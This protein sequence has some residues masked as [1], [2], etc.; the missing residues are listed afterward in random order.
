VI[1]VW[2]R[3]ADLDSHVT[4]GELGDKDSIIVRNWQLIFRTTAGMELGINAFFG[5][6]SK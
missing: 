4:C 6:N 2:V 3:D 1:A 5:Q